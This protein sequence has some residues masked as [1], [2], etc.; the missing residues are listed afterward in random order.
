[1]KMIQS[2]L[3][4]ATA[5]AVSN[6][7]HAQQQQMKTEIAKPVASTVPPPGSKPAL[8]PDTKLV[9]AIP[10]VRSENAVV[11]A[12]SPLTRN[13]ETKQSTETLSAEKLK[14]LNGTAE[15]PKQ[16]ASVLIDQNATALPIVA[17]A[18]IKI[19]E[20]Q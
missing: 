20:N 14:T 16:T 12:P 9:S 1:M 11:A 7:A 19:K 10:M 15:R 17:P 18:V 6:L 2:F 4:I 5:I 8:A 13:D 3:I